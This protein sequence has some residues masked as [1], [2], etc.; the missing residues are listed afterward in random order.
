MGASSQNEL[1][2]P[3]KQ[4]GQRDSVNRSSAAARHFLSHH[5]ELIE[6]KILIAY[7]GSVFANAIL[8]DLRYAGLPQRAEVVVLTVAEPEDFLL[9]KK[10]ESVVVWLGC[11][12]IE[13]RMSSR[14][15]RDCIQANFPGWDV[16]FEASLAAPPQEIIGK[17]MRWNPDLV[18]VGQHGHAGSKRA[19]LPMASWTADHYP[20]LSE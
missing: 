20:Q 8:D 6:M 1:Q 12:L 13:A 4:T 5:H 9:G 11:R 14:L 15:A 17:V 10:T 16:T 18:I 7:D 3:V 19:G 2:G